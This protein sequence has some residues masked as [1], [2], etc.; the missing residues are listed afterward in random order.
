MHSNPDT[1]TRGPELGFCRCFA[2]VINPEF[3]CICDTGYYQGYWFS[4]TLAETKS[5]LEATKRVNFLL[6][7]KSISLQ[8][9][10]Q[11]MDGS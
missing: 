7:F 1:H 3:S 11:K 5:E 4:I 8:Y 6:V 2:D 10:G 9:K